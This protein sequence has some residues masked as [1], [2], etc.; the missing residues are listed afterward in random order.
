MVA[1]SG[2]LFTTETLHDV[3]TR[4]AE[5]QP[6]LNLRNMTQTSRWI[7]GSSF[8]RIENCARNLQL[9]LIGFQVCISP[10]WTLQVK[11]I[12]KRNVV[13]Y[14]QVRARRNYKRSRISTSS[15]FEEYDA[16]LA[17]VTSLSQQNDGIK[18]LLIVIDLFSRYLHVRP[19]KNKTSLIL[20]PF[21]YLIESRSFYHLLL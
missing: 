7:K 8:Y 9:P 10:V 3:T 19:L 5:F 1:E 11:S 14:F 21:L 12:K 4:E 6:L 17:D 18:M 2:Q 20:Q 15:E 16:D 13:W